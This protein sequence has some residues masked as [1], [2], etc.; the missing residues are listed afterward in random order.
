MPT[1]TPGERQISVYFIQHQRKK[2]MLLVYRK[3]CV[4]YPEVKRVYYICVFWYQS[5]KGCLP[6]TSGHTPI[7][8]LQAAADGYIIEQIFTSTV[9]CNKS[10]YFSALA[11]NRRLESTLNNP[12][13]LLALCARSEK[14][15][16]LFK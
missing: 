4:P 5:T 13:D 14:H 1:S 11:P 8:Y 10:A 15:L 9:T 2:I 16:I 7:T 3:V 6:R 12:C